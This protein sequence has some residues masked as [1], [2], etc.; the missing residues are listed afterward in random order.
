MSEDLI[1]DPKKLVAYCN[2]HIQALEAEL[3]EAQTPNDKRII[4]NQL[5]GFTELL[6]KGLHQQ[7]QQGYDTE[8]IAKGSE[9]SKGGRK[10]RFN[11]EGT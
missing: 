11:S 10:T 7:H 9:P 1:D 6:E 5:L 2:K 8:D 3:A 4:R